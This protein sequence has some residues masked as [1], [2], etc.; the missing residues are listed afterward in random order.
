MTSREFK[1]HQRKRREKS[2]QKS[3]F[4]VSK[5]GIEF[6]GGVQC[7]ECGMF[8]DKKVMHKCYSPSENVDEPDEEVYLCP[9]CNDGTWYCMGCGQFCAGISSFDFGE[10]AGY[11]DNCWDEIKSNERDEEDDYNSGDECGFE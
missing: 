5:S 4:V 8:F 3:R 1:Y 10:H 9:E 6:V 7:D 2:E 11:C